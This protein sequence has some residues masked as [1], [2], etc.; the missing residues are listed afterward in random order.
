MINKEAWINKNDE[1]F[2][3]VKSIVNKYDLEMLLMHGTTEDEDE[4]QVR[5][6]LSRGRYIEDSDDMI[7]EIGDIFFY[8]FGTDYKDENLEEMARELVELFS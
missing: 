5:D 8:W 2:L 3:A 6:I 4:P 1:L 7:I